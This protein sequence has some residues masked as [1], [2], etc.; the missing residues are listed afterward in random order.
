MTLEDLV[1]K[2]SGVDYLNK[3][4]QHFSFFTDFTEDCLEDIDDGMLPIITTTLWIEVE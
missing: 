3:E 2:I 4:V 1:S